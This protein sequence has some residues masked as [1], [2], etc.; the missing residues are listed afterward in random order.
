MPLPSIQHGR[1]WKDNYE[2]FEC[3][4]IRLRGPVRSVRNGR[5]SA[6]WIYADVYLPEKY[7][8]NATGR[9]FNPDGTYP[10]EVPINWNRNSL[11]AF[12]ASGDLEWDVRDQ[13]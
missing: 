9:M 3:L 7:S 6:N 2:T 12:L 13:P 1:G 5:R 8:V 10:V 11:R 4:V